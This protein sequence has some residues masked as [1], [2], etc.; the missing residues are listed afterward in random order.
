MAVQT[1]PEIHEDAAANGFEPAGGF[2]YG[3]YGW[4]WLERISYERR[5]SLGAALPSVAHGIAVFAR[6][7]Q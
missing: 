3:L 1:I 6:A 2:G 4:P 5:L 7:P